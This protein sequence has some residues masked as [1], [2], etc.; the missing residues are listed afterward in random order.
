M[1]RVLQIRTKAA[2]QR[3][4]VSM[5]QTPCSFAS[6]QVIDDI[7]NSRQGK[8]L[9]ANQ[10]RLYWLPL[11]DLRPESRWPSLRGSAEEGARLRNGS[12]RR[13]DQTWRTPSPH[14]FRS[15][16]NWKV[17]CPSP[18]T[19]VACDSEVSSSSV[20]VLFSF[21][22][23]LLPVGGTSIR[24]CTKF[25]TSPYCRWGAQSHI[26]EQVPLALNTALTSRT[27]PTPAAC[28]T[29]PNQS[30]FS[31]MPVNSYRQKSGWLCV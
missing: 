14:R 19:G 31:A 1:L 15:Q 7:H 12:L 25:G 27:E 18:R 10:P 4:S 17:P 2:T 22:N 9:D 6:T 5:P 23:N 11:C 3:V 30:I 13:A 24:S 28:D 20:E 16:V 8:I 26:G 29:I 21:Q